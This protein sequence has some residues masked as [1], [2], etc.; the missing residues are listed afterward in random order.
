MGTAPEAVGHLVNANAGIIAQHVQQI[1]EVGD[2]VVGVAVERLVLAQQAHHRFRGVLLHIHRAKARFRGV[3]VVAQV[4]DLVQADAAVQVHLQVDGLHLPPVAHVGA[5]AAD[6]EAPLPAWGGLQLRAGRALPRLHGDARA[7]FRG[8]GIHAHPHRAGVAQARGAAIVVADE[9]RLI[10]AILVVEHPV[11]AAVEYPRIPWRH[12]ADDAAVQ[13]GDVGGTVVFVIGQ[14]EKGIRPAILDFFAIGAPAVFFVAHGVPAI[15]RLG[16]RHAGQINV[17]RELAVRV[18]L[19]EHRRL[20][21]LHLDAAGIRAGTGG[22]DDLVAIII[23]RFI[24]RIFYLC[25]GFQRAIFR[26]GHLHLLHLRAGGK[27]DGGGDGRPCAVRQPH[28]QHGR[29]GFR[30]V[31]RD[32]RDGDAHAQPAIRYFPGQFIRRLRHLY[33]AGIGFRRATALQRPRP[34]HQHLVD[35]VSRR[36]QVQR[37]AAAR[38]A[39]LEAVG[40]GVA[41]VILH[42]RHQRSRQFTIRAEDHR[43]VIR[44]LVIMDVELLGPRI[45]HQRLRGDAG[46]A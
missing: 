32:V 38:R 45:S 30:R 2:G 29:G 37:L 33:A 46:V 39:H 16:E 27:D 43:R 25:D 22:R 13:V 20:A 19:E 40:S 15:A 42:V 41:D 34:L 1:A 10:A 9:R 5:L 6:E 11:A 28:R 8:A 17:I 35:T 12:P 21:R 14:I 44:Q 3:E 31:R 7:L 23:L 36:G 18:L 26:E 24:E 4:G